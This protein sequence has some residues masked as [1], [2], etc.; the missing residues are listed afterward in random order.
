MKQNGRERK[1]TT[2]TMM[3]MDKK[4]Q[5]CYS[6]SLQTFIIVIWRKKVSDE[7]LSSIH[8]KEETHFFVMIRYFLYITVR[9]WEAYFHRH[10]KKL[11]RIYWHLISI[12]IIM[13]KQRRLTC[14]LSSADN[15][16]HQ[17]LASCYTFAVNECELTIL[18]CIYILMNW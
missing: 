12:D 7:I 18:S 10:K 11:S 3:V 4:R 13:Q 14:F 16:I 1:T 17:S 6:T 8:S 9:F 2:A 5:V 15:D